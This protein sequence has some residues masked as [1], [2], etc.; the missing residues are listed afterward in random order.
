[1]KALESFS[2]LVNKVCLIHVR[3]LMEGRLQKIKWKMWKLLSRLSLFSWL[4]YLTGQ[5]TFK[6]VVTNSFCFPFLPTNHFPGAHSGHDQSTEA[7]DF[8]PWASRIWN[9]AF[10]Y[11]LIFVDL[12]VLKTFS[13]KKLRMGMFFFSQAPPV[14]L[15]SHLPN[16][17]LFPSWSLDNFQMTK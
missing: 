10:S 5:C 8:F 1:M 11:G 14:N 2:K 9:L 13:Q 12:N 7:S 6:W 3:C 17:F 15:I 4:W 16:S